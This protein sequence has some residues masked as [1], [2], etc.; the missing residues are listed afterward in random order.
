VNNP[1]F[2]IVRYANGSAGKFLTS[3][4]MSS[5]S[6]SHFDSNVENNKTDDACL[7]YIQTHFV[8]NLNNWLVHEPK[9]TDAWN[10]HHVSSNYPRGDNLTNDQFLSIAKTDATSYFWKSVSDNK[11]IPFIWHKSSVPDFFKN[12]KFITIILDQKSIKWYHRARWYKQYSLVN[13][14]IHLN[15]HDPNFNSSKLNKYYEQ[16]KNVVDVDSSVYSFI[17]H[18]IIRDN[19][20]KL[21]QTTDTFAQQSIDQEFINLSDILDVNRCITRLNQ[22]CNNYKLDLISPDLIR[23]G[24]THWSNCHTFKYA[25]R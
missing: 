13:G 3:L 17:K 21:F 7:N 20:K 11:V 4:L 25:M 2:L 19:K 22:I 10:L 9:H 6:V 14:K 16:F 18:N 1:K 24:H 8:K 5:T 15:E 12:A 23:Q